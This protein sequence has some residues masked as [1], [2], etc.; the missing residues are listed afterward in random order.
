M[1]AMP[2]RFQDTDRAAALEKALAARR[3]YAKAKAD[4]AAGSISLAEALEDPALARM[5]V[6]PLLRAVPGVGPARAAKIILACGIS[7]TRR[8][9]GLGSRQR[10]AL[11]GAVQ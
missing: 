8:V 7:K 5:R 9:G 4:L 1:T 6:E 10:R 2:S 3:T 11:L